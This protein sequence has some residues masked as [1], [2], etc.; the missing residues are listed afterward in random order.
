M[1]KGGHG[2]V[3]GF[4]GG[5][6]DSWGLSPAPQGVWGK[7]TES[8]A[9]RSGLSPLPLETPGTEGPLCGSCKSLTLGFAWVSR[10]VG[11]E[12]EDA[13]GLG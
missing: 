6:R 12:R 4:I 11:E 13:G 5:G 7:G 1:A 9:R 8:E 2:R 10:W 3:E